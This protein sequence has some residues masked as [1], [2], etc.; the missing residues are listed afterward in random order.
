MKFALGVLFWLSFA[1]FGQAKV[2]NILLIVS[3]D[4]KADALSCY[5]NSIA[6]TPNID[7]LAGTGMHYKNANCQGTRSAPPRAKLIQNNTPRANFTWN[8]KKKDFFEYWLLD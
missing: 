7:R 5:G 3:D 4:L 6:H 1:I 2:K 8:V